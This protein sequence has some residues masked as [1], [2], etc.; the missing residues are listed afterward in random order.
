[1]RGGAESGNSVSWPGGGRGGDMEET[2]ETGL[3]AQS[4]TAAWNG[5]AQWCER[6][7]SSARSGRRLNDC[8]GQS[9]IVGWPLTVDRWTRHAGYP[10]QTRAVTW[11]THIEVES[12]HRSAAAF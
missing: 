12:S 5:K 11:R 7:W 4:Q 8:L 1:L 6:F 2:S 9:S 10:V 3:L